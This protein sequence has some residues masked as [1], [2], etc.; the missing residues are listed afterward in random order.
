[1]TS[2]RRVLSRGFLQ[3]SA[4][5]ML[6]LALLPSA[7]S[8]GSLT[9]ELTA[10]QK[11]LVE[12]NVDGAL[13]S[14]DNAEAAAAE[15]DTVAVPGIVGKVHYYRGMGLYMQGDQ[16]GAM[17]EWRT[18][19]LIDNELQWDEAIAKDGQAQD[20]FEALRKEVRDRPSV[21]GHIPPLVGLA[22][23]YVDG[24]RVCPGDR[25]Q[26]GTHLLQV[27]CPDDR[28]HGDWATFPKKKYKW[29]K[30]CP[31]GLDVNAIPE[32][33]APAEEDM[34]SFDDALGG[35]EEGCPLPG[36]EP[37]VADIPADPIAPPPGPAPLI[38]HRVS[39]PMVA[40]GGGLLVGGGVALAIA[41]SRRSAFEADMN[42]FTSVGEVET[43]ASE[44][45]KVAWVGTG[46]S[47][48]GGGLCVAAVI[49]W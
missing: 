31:N 6:G 37:E 14:V 16:E 22:K 8:A 46:L 41:S 36:E 20:L 30:L 26:E 43:R 25:I 7:A 19:L 17:S 3:R 21:E 49:P 5:W 40:A 33:E 13:A 24:S 32:P 27:D 4:G 45:N 44:V 9:D 29:L 11:A 18:A 1:M 42:S 23:L 39:W 34:F 35:E 2:P 12:K 15:L 48:V 47:V 28:I 10:A 38:E